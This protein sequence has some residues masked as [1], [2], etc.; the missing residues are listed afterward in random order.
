MKHVW[1]VESAPKGAWIAVHLSRRRADARQ[2]VRSVC[3]LDIEGLPFI[4]LRIRKY[5]RAEA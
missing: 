3:A 2:F 4:P 5:V 1:I